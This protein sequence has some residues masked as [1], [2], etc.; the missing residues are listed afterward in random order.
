MV[1]RLPVEEE[2]A[3]SIP[4]SHPRIFEVALGKSS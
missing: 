2:A 4:V 1:E 3:G